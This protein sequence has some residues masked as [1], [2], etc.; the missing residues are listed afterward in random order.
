MRAYEECIG[1][2]KHLV[3]GLSAHTGPMEGSKSFAIG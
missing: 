2:K 1:A 3:T